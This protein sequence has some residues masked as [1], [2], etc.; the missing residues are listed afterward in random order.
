MPV[1]LSAI[2]KEVIILRAV[3][4]LI[5]DMV[6]F[7]MMSI[8]GA[9][10]HSQVTF[11]SET[12]LRLFN[13]ML[14]DFLSATGKR[15]PIDPTSYMSALQGIAKEPNFDREDSGNA[16]RSAVAE[17]VQWLD[18]EVAVETW[19]PSID[20][21]VTLKLSRRQF[22][23]MCGNISKHNFLRL[24]S[25]AEELQE[26]LRKTGTQISLDDALLTLED[27]YTKFHRDV[28]A[29]HA[30]TIAEF[31]N[32]LRWGIYEYLRPEFK[33]SYTRIAGDSLGRYEYRYPEGLNAKFAQAC[34]WDL[35]NDIRSAPYLRRFETT[36]FLKMHF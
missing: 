22:I 6:N 18:T 26:L 12:H 15:G 11:K 27:F 3:Y 30:S 13:I 7:V 32:N 36:K 35:M 28:I 31:L 17:F 21:E 20:T 4:A 10:P 2:E 14:V 33:R 16:F 1:E 9:D 25:V 24:I 34:Y 8:S 19:L 29:Y 23:K 5:D